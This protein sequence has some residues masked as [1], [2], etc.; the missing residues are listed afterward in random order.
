[1]DRR[2][3]VKTVPAL[4]MMAGAPSA[5]AEE[6]QPITLAKPEEEGGKPWALGCICCLL[7]SATAACG[8][9]PPPPT[10]VKDIDFPELVRLAERYGLPRPPEK[11]PLVLA[12]MGG[13]AMLG[14]SSTSHDPGV[15][16]PAFLL[17]RL[18]QDRARVL[19]GWETKVVDPGAD[20]CPATRPYSLTRPKPAL[21]GYVLECNNLSLFVTAV[22]L[23]QRGATDDAGRLWDQVKAAEFFGD[24]DASEDVGRLRAEP[25]LL[26]AHCLYQHFY[27]S[28]LAENAGLK[29][30]HDKLLLLEKEFP[31]LFSDDSKSYYRYRRSRFVRDLGL[32]VQ[33]RH[34]PEGSVE[35]LLV[36]WGNRTGEYRHLG[37][38]EEYDVEADRPAREIFLRGVKAL[39]D[40]AK[41]LDDQRLT[42]HVSPAIMMQPEERVRLGELAKKLLADM[43][44]ARGP[45]AVE[46]VGNGRDAERRFF[47]QAAVTSTDAKI[48]AFHEVPLWILGQK[49]PQSLLAIC[50]KVP[51]EA[52]A[53]V[54]LFAPVEAV[55]RSKL[56][57]Q[58]KADAL[59]GMCE[60]LGD[61]RRQRFVLQRLAKLDEERCVALLRPILA[62]L[63]DD[64]NEPYWTCEAAYYTQVV[65]ELHDDGIWKDYLKIA[66]RAAVGLRMEMMNSMNYSYIG[67]TNR[68]RRLAWLAEFLDDAALRDCAADRHRYDGPCAAFTI[69]KLEV[70]DFAAMQ[71]ASLLNFD[72]RPTE[73]WTKAEWAQL[74]SKVRTELNKRNLYPGDGSSPKRP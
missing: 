30:I 40:L 46:S 32:T 51:A 62:R 68:G 18:P 41:L 44:G 61:Y 64:V 58:E 71:I 5:F 34:A 7:L 53:D 47:E 72:D 37:Y 50:A 9:Q 22:Q 42:R 12:F 27:H 74:R 31:V 26:L 16:L 39:P 1:M 38:F 56:T 55:A 2:T 63:P 15:Y 21:K 23:A 11:A 25:R 24:G 49:D 10:P 3:F 20:Y 33:A 36:D 48:A 59:A 14:S 54:P 6:P 70:R 13:C 52:T 19:M 73:F 60:R 67:D 28:T 43:S 57:R 17:E 8:A 4:A 45:K 35:A 69:E 29:S 66:K 65:M